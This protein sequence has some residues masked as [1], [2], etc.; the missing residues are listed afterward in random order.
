MLSENDELGNPDGPPLF[1]RV[2]RVRWREV[3]ASRLV[4]LPA[5]LRIMEETEYAFLR[6]RGLSSV[7]R[8]H[9]GIIGFPRV[10]TRIQVVRPA[11]LHAELDIWFRVPAN[12]GVKLE[13]RFDIEHLSEPVARGQ[14][15]V[16]CCRF[17]GGQPPRAI[18]IPDVYL[19]QIPILPDDGPSFT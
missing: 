4:Q 17:T 10:A 12:D 6:S 8:D 2:H 13:Y 1:H 15:S 16:A 3:D 19:R 18:L 9:R 14:F 11:G 7:M 5:W